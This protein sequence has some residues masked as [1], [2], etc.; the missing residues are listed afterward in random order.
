MKQPI[1]TYLVALAVGDLKFQS[2]GE[3][4]G[5]YAEPKVLPKAAWEFAETERMITAAEKL[6]G[7][8]RWDRYDLVVLPPSFPF[9]GMENPRLTF[10]TPTILAGDRSLVALVAHELAHSWSGNLV[11]NATWND[12]WLNE[13][14]TVYF[15]QR[16]ME[17]VYGRKYSEM[18]AK[19]SLESLQQEIKELSP[20]DTWLKLDLQDRN[21]DDGMTSIAYDK[22]YFFLRRLEETFGREHWDA[23]LKK[24]FQRFAFQTMTT[25]EFLSFVKAELVANHPEQATVNLEQ[26]VYGPGL[27]E[28]CPQV[29]SDELTSARKLAKRFQSGESVKGKDA[30]DWST[31]HWL[32]FLRSFDSNLSIDQMHQ[33]DKTF[34]FSAQGNTEILFAWLLLSVKNDYEAA[35]PALRQFLRNQGRRKF[36]VPIYRQLSLTDKGRRLGREIYAEARRGYHPIS[37]ATVDQILLGD[38]AKDGSKK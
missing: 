30:E 38:A 4:S 1:P 29:D 35:H 28:D 32:H 23:F 11:T 5:V 22:G 36:L 7:P 20:R 19:L 34:E 14:F 24:Y 15:E 26:W 16:I 8:Y 2:L 12:F 18:L 3:R 33:L 9:G 31:H 27:P 13:G 10:A 21:P 17:S 25:E 6:Y 37:Q